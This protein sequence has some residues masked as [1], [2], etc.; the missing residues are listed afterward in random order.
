MQCC[1]ALQRRDS[2]LAS[3]DHWWNGFFAPPPPGMHCMHWDVVGN[4]ILGPRLD[5]IPFGTSWDPLWDSVGTLWFWELFG[6]LCLGTV[7]ESI[8]RDIHRT[9]I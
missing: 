4:L 6:T 1:D 7:W 2:A 8:L 3:V 5:A 9:D